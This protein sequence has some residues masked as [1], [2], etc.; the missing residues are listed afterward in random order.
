MDVVT[1]LGTM[2][3]YNTLGGHVALG[4]SGPD[5][6]VVGVLS[7]STRCVCVLGLLS[8]NRLRSLPR[9]LESRNKPSHS[10]ADRV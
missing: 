7:R 10:G 4:C 6:G 9:G 1:S 3:S 8:P 2:S 5:A